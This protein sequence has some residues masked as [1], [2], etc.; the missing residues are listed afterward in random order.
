M[1]RPPDQRKREELLRGIRD[2]I[3]EYGLAE[4]SLRPLAAALGTSDRM[5]LH[6]FETKDNLLAQALA[7]GIPE[8]HLAFEHVDDLPAMQSSLRDL[9]R[10]MTTGSDVQPIRILL[11]AMG[12]ACVGP[13][14]FTEHV[15]TVF[16]T[17][18]D[19]LADSLYRCGV[20][21]ADAQLQ[22]TVLAAGFRGLLF[23]QLI[24]GDKVRTDAA[25]DILVRDL[26][27]AEKV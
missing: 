2:Y 23:D 27:A 24:T 22:A 19:A 26:I 16:A 6:Y 21:R 4:L 10:S 1:P 17:L 9:W 12:I 25:V 7:S 20:P 3:S 8:F 14:R 15:T 11:Q 18:T 13:G 5:L